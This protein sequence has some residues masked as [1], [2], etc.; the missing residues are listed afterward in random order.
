MD[1][2]MLQRIVLLSLIVMASALRAD[3]DGEDAGWDVEKVPGPERTQKI[4]TDEGTWISVDVS[5][6][7]R[8]IVF[9]LLGDI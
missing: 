5:R 1:E 9:D 4:D 8:R 3:E 2:F 7:A 6:D